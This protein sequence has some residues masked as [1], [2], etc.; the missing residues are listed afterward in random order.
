MKWLSFLIFVCLGIGL[1]YTSATCADLEGS[2][3][4]QSIVHSSLDGTEEI[5][6]QL[7]GPLEPVLFS[8]NGEKPRL[9]ADFYNGLFKGKRVVPVKDG[10]LVTAIR[11]GMHVSPKK[12]LRVVIDL[13]KEIPVEFVQNFSEGTNLLVITIKPVVASTEK[14]QELQSKESQPLMEEKKLPSREELEAK[15]LDE[16]PVPPVF[17]TQSTEEKVVIDDGGGM[18]GALEGAQILEISFD[19]TSNRGEMVLFRL[20]DFYPPVVSALEKENPRIICDF[21]DMGIAVGVQNS[22][23]ANGKYV[24]RIKTTR[25]SNPDKVRIVLELAP[26]RDYDLQQVFF[27]NDNLF[28]LIIN[29]LVPEAVVDKEDAAQ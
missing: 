20:N 22:I 25:E 11:T 1:T 2:I 15:P 14:K 29:E 18:G 16:K 9:V 4:V 6:F 10:M 17:S 21:M 26:D 13:S 5:S 3:E 28:V 12:K 24:Q 23:H 8:L 7:S 27:K 19:D